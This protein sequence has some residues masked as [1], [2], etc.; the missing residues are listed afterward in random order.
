[1]NNQRGQRASVRVESG[2]WLGYWNTYAYD[3]STDKKMRKQRSAKPGPKFLSKFQTY[4]LLRSTFSIRCWYQASAPARRRHNCGT[5]HAH[6]LAVDEG[7]PMAGSSQAGANHV[8]SHI[9]KE[10]GETPRQRVSESA[11]LIC[12]TGSTGFPES[13]QE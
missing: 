1:M 9:Y 4:K 3:P 8:L 2:S 13:Q 6:A 10:F 5:V 7:S 12:K 11:K